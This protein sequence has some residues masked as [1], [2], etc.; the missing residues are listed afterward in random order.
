MTGNS[1]LKPK[2][3]C[4]K[5]DI[6][7]IEEKSRKISKKK[8]DLRRNTPKKK[9]GL[10]KEDRSKLN[11]NTDGKPQNKIFEGGGL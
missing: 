5:K 2:N 3:I 8:L 9:R 4:M 7:Q 6:M 10:V 11:T 1:P